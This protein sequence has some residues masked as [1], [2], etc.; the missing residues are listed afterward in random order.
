MARGHGEQARESSS[1]SAAPAELVSGLACVHLPHPRGP[2]ALSCEGGLSQPCGVGTAV[3]ATSRSACWLTWGELA[4]QGSTCSP[5]H[6]PD[7]PSSLHAFLVAPQLPVTPGSNML[8]FTQTTRLAL[9]R[10]SWPCESQNAVFYKPALSIK[11]ISS[12]LF[13]REMP[14]W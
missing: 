1:L 12:P 9:L 14:P 11:C 6:P 10:A 4:A 3:L 2:G 8:G 5:S 7:C 13:I